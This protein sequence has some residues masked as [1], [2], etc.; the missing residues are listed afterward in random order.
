MMRSS[1]SSSSSLWDVVVNNDDI[2]FIH[3]LPRLNAT[4]I[5]FLYGVNSGTR[6]L[7]KRSTR[8]SDLKKKFKVEEMSSISTLEVAWEHK[9]LWPFW[10]TETYFCEK[11]AETNK[12]ELLEWAREEKYCDW[13]ERTI[14]AASIQGNLE[15]VKYC[16][17]NKCPIDWRTC[18]CAAKNGHLEILKYLREE[19]KAPWDW[20]T[21]SWA[22]ESGHLHIL[23]YL[24]ER[25]YDKFD[26]YACEYAA[27]HGHLDCLKYLH[28]TAKAPWDYRAVREAHENNH[29]E[30]VQY[31]LDNNCLLPRVTSLPSSTRATT[32][33]SIN[34]PSSSSSSS[35]KGNNNNKRGFRA[36]SSSSEQPAKIQET[37]Q[38]HSP[39]GKVTFAHETD[40]EKSKWTNCEISHVGDVN[41]QAKVKL[42]IVI[43]EFHDQLMNRMLEDARLSALAMNAEI[44]RVVFVPGTY[45]APLILENMLMD[46]SLDAA[47]VLGYIEKGSTLHGEEMGNTCSLIFKQLELEYR[48]PV[49]MGIIGPGATAEQAETRVAYAGNAIRAAIR[50]ARTMMV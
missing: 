27:Y 37:Y 39:E 40:G 23:E 13:D 5:K 28:E 46:D 22:A 38:F 21:A 19:A 15:M 45:E 10:W 42:G 47:C 49:G 12:L 25:K 34:R 20:D 24:V 50:M 14:T 31:F 8:E 6:K 26:A 7:I 44:T 3:I 1:S 4:D 17:A 48:K 9:S 11:V 43:G 32:N 41:E 35:K 18:A 2:T 29:P 36:S 33:N 16:V 30:C